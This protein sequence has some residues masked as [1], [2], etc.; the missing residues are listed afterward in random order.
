[1][2][3]KK[4]SR[5]SNSPRLFDPYISTTDDRLLAIEPGSGLPYWQ[6]LGLSSA[7][8]TDWHNKRMFWDAPV[9]GLFAQYSNP[10]ISTGSVKKRVKLFINDFR[11][12]ANPLLNLIAASPNASP[13][14]EDI[15]N[16]VLNVNRQKPS[17]PHTHIADQC[18]TDWLGGKGG[19]MKAVSRSSHDTKRASLAERADGVQYA[20]KIMD[21]KP[22]AVESEEAG[23][24]T[25]TKLK[26]GPQNPDD[27]TKQEF[28]SGATHEFIFGA[29]KEGMYLCIWTRWFHSKHPELAGA[30]SEM[31]TVLIG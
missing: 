14:D 6:Y 19:N 2:V 20:W 15:F 17:H 21:T 11:I 8:A 3:S 30:W 22:N 13:N 25:A 28:F 4:G 1:M 9:T 23:N 10:D 12:F 5:I 31:Q 18:F 7:N 24:E 29:D 26:R 16:L 27:G